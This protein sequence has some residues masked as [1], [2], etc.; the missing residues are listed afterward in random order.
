MSSRKRVAYDAEFKL[1]AISYTKEHGNRPAAR[2]FHVNECMVRRWRQQEDE[3]RLARKTKKSFRRR[4]AQW[5][6]L[7][8]R[9]YQW[10]SERRAAGRSVSTVA[11][12]VQAKAIAKQL[13]IEEFK[14][15][16]SVRTRTTVCQ[17]LPADYKEKVARFRSYCKDKISENSIQPHCIINMDEVPLTFDM[18][19]TRTVEHTGTA[20][21]PV[22][23]TGNEKTSFTVVLDVSLAGQKL[24]PMVIFK[25]KTLPKE[26]FP[27]GIKVHANSKGWMDEDAMK[28]W[29][30][31]VYGGTLHRFLNQLPGLLILDSMRAHTTETV[32]EIA[33]IKK[34]K[35]AVIPGGLTKELQPLDIG[36]I[37]S[38]KSKVRSLWEEWMLEGEH[39]YTNT[40][41]LRRASYATVCQWIL[42]AWGKVTTRTISRGFAKADVIPGLTS[43]AIGSTEGDNSDGEGAGKT[44]SR[45]LDPTIAQQPGSVGNAR[46]MTTLLFLSFS[47]CK[48]NLQGTVP[49]LSS[50][51]FFTWKQCFRG[52]Q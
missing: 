18:P 6:E 46:K 29:L 8:E 47:A 13:H 10:I 51:S 43:N 48:Q 32:T 26:R 35:L 39:S 2:A 34:T 17:R 25:R 11:I 5:P 31:D 22:R 44:T 21:V 14:T 19:L 16:L 30:R 40:G 12:R 38:F 49:Q 42:D 1:K 37:R 24:R 9:L 50:V 41:R 7:E 4:R 15:G 20:T 45:S 28:I 3:L 23:T 33:R 27:R 36:I 52:W